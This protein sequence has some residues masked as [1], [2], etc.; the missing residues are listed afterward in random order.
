MGQ[1]PRTTV[2]P[3]TNIQTDF[4]NAVKTGE[5]VKADSLKELAQKLQLPYASLER[6]VNSYN[7]AGKQ[8]EDATFLKPASELLFAVQEGPFYAIIE[9]CAMLTAIVNRLKKTALH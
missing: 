5:V 9:H 1:T 2:G 8:K 7:Q 6:S 4:D 3:L